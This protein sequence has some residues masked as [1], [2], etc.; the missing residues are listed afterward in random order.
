MIGQGTEIYRRYE[1]FTY[2]GPFWREDF[3]SEYV[4]RGRVVLSIGFKLNRF[5][6]EHRRMGRDEGVDEM[7]IRR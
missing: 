6:F 1:G 3:Q 4:G 5:C 2:C 7:G